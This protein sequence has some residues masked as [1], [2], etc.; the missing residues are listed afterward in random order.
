MVTMALTGWRRWLYRIGQVLAS[1]GFSLL[2]KD[3]SKDEWVLVWETP[4][5]R[6]YEKKGRT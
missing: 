5:E 4:T 1:G 2:S 3:E 6:R